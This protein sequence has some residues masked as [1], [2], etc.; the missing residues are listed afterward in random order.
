M[1]KLRMDRMNKLLREELSWIIQHKINSPE[2]HS[3]EIGIITITNIKASPDLRQAKVYVSFIGNED[4]KKAL[5]ALKASVKPIKKILS[6]RTKLRF[7]PELYFYKDDTVEELQKIDKL[8]D[9]IKS[10][11]REE[12]IDE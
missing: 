5:K 11:P 10:E 7:T 12:N 3:P 4:D 9:K 6:Q 2:I 8:F 1:S